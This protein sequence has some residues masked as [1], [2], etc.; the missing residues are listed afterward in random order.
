MTIGTGYYYGSVTA[1]SPPLSWL[2]SSLRRQSFISLYPSARAG[3]R[4]RNAGHVLNRDVTKLSPSKLILYKLSHA[5]LD[6]AL[7]GED[8]EFTWCACYVGTLFL[9]CGCE[10]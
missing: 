8:S 1:A 10:G 4:A 3:A 6:L 7:P 2:N 9:R 5:D